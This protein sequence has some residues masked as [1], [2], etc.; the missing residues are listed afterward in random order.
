MAGARV[1]NASRSTAQ[2]SPTL[3]TGWEAENRSS[4]GDMTK[5][6][7]ES[8]EG[9]RTGLGNHHQTGRKLTAVALSCGSLMC[10]L[11]HEEG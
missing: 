6:P 11:R 4:Q 3:G 9:M 1:S 7:G 8:D 2:N 10:H 5:S